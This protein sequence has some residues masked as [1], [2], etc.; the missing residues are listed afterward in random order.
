MRREE[1]VRY[2]LEVLLAIKPSTEF[3][4]INNTARISELRWVLG[5]A[6]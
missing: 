6:E 1:E 3:G 5:E 2:H 4:H